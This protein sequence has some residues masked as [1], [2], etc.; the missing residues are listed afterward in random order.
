MMRF[1]P[2]VGLITILILAA[3]GCESTSTSASA[4]TSAETDD[5]ALAATGPQRYRATIDDDDEDDGDEEEDEI[6]VPLSEVPDNV[7]DA[8]L[9]AV[10]GIELEEA[11]VETENGIVIYDIEGEL[12]GVEY[13]IEVTEAGEVLEIETDDED[14]DDDDDDD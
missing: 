3:F 9:A 12:D 7:I 13:E 6:E 14:D 10:P 8:A 2:I 5:I 1:T 11:E 4:D